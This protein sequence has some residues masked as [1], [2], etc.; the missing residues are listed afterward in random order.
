MKQLEEQRRRQA[1]NYQQTEQALKE[2]YSESTMADKM[3][4]Q[5]HHRQNEVL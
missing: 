4:S 5:Y 3:E 1:E 2:K